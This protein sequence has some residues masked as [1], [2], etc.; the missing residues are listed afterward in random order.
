[1]KTIRVDTWD[2]FKTFVTTR[3]IH[4]QELLLDGYYYLYAIDGPFSISFVI[5]KNDPANADQLDY[6]TNFQ[7]YS[8]QS[9]T[10]SKGIQLHRTKAFANTDGLKFRGTGV[11]GTAL[12]GITEQQPTIT[13]IDYI[14]PEDR[15]INGIEIF[16]KN[17]KAEDTINLQV[18]H[19]INNDVLDEFSTNWNIAEDTERQGQY[20]VPYPALIYQGFILRMAYTATGIINNVDVKANY[21]LH[22]KP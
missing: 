13:N 10:D 19:P 18:V 2:I 7:P 5:E 6:E 11:K 17:H 3:N 16:L 4:I 14:L 8:N 21:F 20:V 9:F 1:M 12:K 22:K 15:Y